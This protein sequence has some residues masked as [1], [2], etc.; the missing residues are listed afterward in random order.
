MYQGLSACDHICP[1]CGARLRMWRNTCSRCGKK[2][3]ADSALRKMGIAILI[4]GLGLS[5]VISYLAWV[6]ALVMRHSGDPGAT[7]RFTGTPLQAVM[8]FGVFGFVLL[9]GL[10]L[11]AGGVFQI[12][13]CR[14][15]TYATKVALFW[16]TAIWELY[17]IAVAA[18]WVEWQLE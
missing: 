17:G 6:V 16:D 13:Y 18:E 1:Q 12:V 11:L 4:L 9:V 10:T 5:G 8:I 3:R 7:M 15:N 14:K 2:I